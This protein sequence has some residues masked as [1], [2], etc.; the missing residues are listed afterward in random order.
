MRPQYL[1]A[2]S[3]N[4]CYPNYANMASMQMVGYQKL[5]CS[6]ANKIG[7]RLKQPDHSIFNRVYLSTDTIHWLHT[8]LLKLLG[9]K[10]L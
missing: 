9:G 3:L 8:G 6:V 7:S 2:S 4:C 10:R 1:K 5:N